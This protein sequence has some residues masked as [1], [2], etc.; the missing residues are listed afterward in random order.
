MALT[1]KHGT[2]MPTNVVSFD[3][4]QYSDVK[5]DLVKPFSLLDGSRSIQMSGAPFR[6]GV[7]A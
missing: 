5:L 7:F 4:V 2:L 6:L 3:L 1:M